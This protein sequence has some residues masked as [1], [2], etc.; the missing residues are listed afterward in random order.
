MDDPPHPWQA[1]KLAH[2]RWLL[3]KVQT[4]LPLGCQLGCM[5]AGAP[6]KVHGHAPTTHAAAILSRR[7]APCCSLRRWAKCQFSVP[8]NALRQAVHSLAEE[9]GSKKDDKGQRQHPNRAAPRAVGSRAHPGE[10]RHWTFRMA[11]CGRFGRFRRGWR[12]STALAADQLVLLQGRPWCPPFS[13]TVQATC[14]LQQLYFV[15][16]QLD[17][18]RKPSCGSALVFK[19]PAVLSQPRFR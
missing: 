8:C 7:D 5:P 6:C 10:T 1:C 16:M 19:N 9:G 15:K 12:K 4:S 2:L 13:R 11:I 3:V 18:C 14:V 17:T